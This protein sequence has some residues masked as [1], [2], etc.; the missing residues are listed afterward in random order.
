MPKSLKPRGN[1]SKFNWYFESPV[2]YLSNWDCTVRVEKR[3]G[4]FFRSVKAIW[5]FQGQMNVIPSWLG[6][7]I[8][9]S[10]AYSD[11]GSQ[12]PSHAP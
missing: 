2:K 5:P 3:L 4:L 12:D 10:V 1:I 8:F 6:I 9:I 7:Q 11:K